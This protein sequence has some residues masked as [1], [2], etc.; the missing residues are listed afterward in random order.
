MRASFLSRVKASTDVEETVEETGE[1]TTD[2]EPTWSDFEHLLKKSH[3]GV[4]FIGK[5]PFMCSFL[6]PIPKA[7]TGLWWTSWI[8]KHCV[9]ACAVHGLL[10]RRAGL[11]SCCNQSRV[12]ASPS[13]SPGDVIRQLRVLGQASFSGYARS[14]GQTQKA[15]VCHRYLVSYNQHTI[16]G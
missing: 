5:V 7:V 9:A 13:G 4:Q 12:E 14:S 10:V 11:C 1:Q 16:A 6:G 15:H 2:W 8:T 3:G